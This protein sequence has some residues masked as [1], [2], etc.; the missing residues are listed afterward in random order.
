MILCGLGEGTMFRSSI[1]HPS[2][3]YNTKGNLVNYDVYGS[4]P[5]STGEFILIIFNKGLYFMK[6][7]K[8][9]FFNK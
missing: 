5:V 3:G 9:I 4:I 8:K 7:A 2:S 6:K 1:L